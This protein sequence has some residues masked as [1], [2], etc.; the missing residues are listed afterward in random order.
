MTALRLALVALL[1][2]L[3]AQLTGW[4]LLDQLA[5]TLVGIITVAAL[6][7]WS[8]RRGLALTRRR[9]FERGQVGQT[10]QEHLTLTNTSRLPKLWVEVEDRS[11]LPGHLVS[12]VVSLA[13]RSDRHWTVETPLT[14]RG[15]YRLGPLRLHTSDPFGLFPSQRVE[16]ASSELLVYP[17]TIPLIG[18]TLLAGDRPGGDVIRSRTP[19]ATPSVNSIR[20]YQ[21]GDSFNRIA[22]ALSARAGRLMVKEFE[23]DPSADIWLIIDMAYWAHQLVGPAGG[24]RPPPGERWRESTEEFSVTVAASLGQHLLAQ[25][26]AVGLLMAGQHQISLPTDRGPRQQLKL[27]EALAVVRAGGARDL[28][29]LLTAEATRFSRH[30]TL[31]IITPTTD[32]Q[33]LTVLPP[34][35]RTGAHASVILIDAS[36]FGLP[37]GPLLTV[38]HLAAMRVPTHILRQQDDLAGLLAQPALIPSAAGPRWQ[39][40][41]RA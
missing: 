16:R 25:K 4:R 35:L 38:A 2:L 37:V 20:D 40:P 18:L 21:P 31:L 27:L 5:Y 41:E 30:C 13:G 36:S 39:R 23:F 8:S 14:R 33:W 15:R 28:A 11:T 17:A 24:W 6:V 12:R 3:A 34:L 19:Q 29:E 32:E 22:W 1:S 9:A 10:L 7:S 26:R